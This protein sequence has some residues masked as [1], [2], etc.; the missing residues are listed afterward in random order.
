MIGG[1]GVFTRSRSFQSRGLRITLPLRLGAAGRWAG[2]LSRLL[3]GCRELRAERA[4]RVVEDDK[5]ASAADID[6]CL[7]AE[8]STFHRPIVLI[9][10]DDSEIDCLGQGDPAGWPGDDVPLVI[11]VLLV[12]RVRTHQG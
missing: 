9:K 11:F 12:P 10:L 3:R 7:W 4:R 5:Q 1:F 2:D 6:L 8:E